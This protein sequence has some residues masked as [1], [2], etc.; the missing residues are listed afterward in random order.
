MKIADILNV[1]GR[2]V[3]TA[4]PWTTVAEAVNRLNTHGIGAILACDADRKI[5]GI[6][7]ERDIIR[8]L[9][10]HGSELLNMK[11]DDVMTHHVVTCA[12]DETVANA[13]ALMTRGRY[14]HLPVVDNGSLIGMVSIGDLV[15]HRV[16]EMELETG[17]LRDAVIA[18]Y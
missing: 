12:P 15:K 16:R 18:R 6:I 8:G 3:H 11:I 5:C 17:V 13:M 14:R 2:T 1:K 7:S 10:R 9:G 4:L